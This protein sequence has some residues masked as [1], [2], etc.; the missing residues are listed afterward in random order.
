[1][2][3]V[4][5]RVACAGLWWHR[6][7]LDAH[8]HGARSVDASRSGFMWLCFLVLL[9]SE[10][11]GS[12]CALEGP[13]Q[14]EKGVAGVAPPLVVAPCDLGPGRSTVTCMVD[15]LVIVACTAPDPSFFDVE[16]DDDAPTQLI[17]RPDH[18]DPLQLPRFLVPVQWSGRF[19]YRHPADSVRPEEASQRS[20]VPQTGP[21]TDAKFLFQVSP[22]QMVASKT[23]A[24]HTT[25]FF[26]ASYWGAASGESPSSVKEDAVLMMNAAL[27]ESMPSNCG[28]LS[29]V[30]SLVNHV[31]P[32][33][34]SLDSLPQRRFDAMGGL[35]ML[36]ARDAQ[37]R[38]GRTFASQA[39][40]FGPLRFA[41]TGEPEGYLAST[42]EPREASK[43]LEAKA[44]LDTY[45]GNTFCVQGDVP[46]A[47]RGYYG[48]FL[49]RSGP[50]QEIIAQIVL[51]DVNGAR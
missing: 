21:S 8:G 31:S 50:A 10:A 35:R 29:K 18:L 43:W 6:R 13:G 14:S 17:T 23:I 34:R 24:N 33:P 45:I 22:G 20:M 5:L 36:H 3:G 9:A 40:V 32:N 49:E 37:E 26:V 30:A 11:L 44:A 16:V 39:R 19:P 25:R 2:G 38:R 41:V 42:L 15:E 28:V 4:L 48:A 27:V 51:R 46:N 1:M 12:G 7:R 47:W